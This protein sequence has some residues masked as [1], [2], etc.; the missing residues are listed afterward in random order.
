MNFFS[1][2]NAEK[3]NIS[4]ETYVVGGRYGLETP[5][6]VV[7]FPG[8]RHKKRVMG[9]REISIRDYLERRFIKKLVRT[10]PKSTEW[11]GPEKR[12][13]RGNGRLDRSYHNGLQFHFYEISNSGKLK[14]II[15]KLEEEYGLTINKEL[16]DFLVSDL[17]R[18][19]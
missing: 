7:G 6:V 2:F 9:E 19:V 4:I 11:L 12:D 8:S 10:K 3:G 16:P 5:L 18:I 17:E 14:Q 15:G 13:F 1:L